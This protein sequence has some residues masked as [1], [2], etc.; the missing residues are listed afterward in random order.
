MGIIKK[1]AISSGSEFDFLDEVDSV[2]RSC[3]AS[4]SQ[5]VKDIPDLYAETNDGYSGS[6]SMTYSVGGGV[7]TVRIQTGKQRGRSPTKITGGAH[8][9]TYPIASNNAANALT[10]IV[11][12]QSGA[13]LT[14]VVKY[15]TQTKYA[16]DNAVRECRIGC[17]YNPGVL[18][19]Y[20]SDYDAAMVGT[21]S[22]LGILLIS[23]SSDHVFV[24]TKPGSS[25]NTTG[26]L[27]DNGAS[28][29]PVTRLP[30]YRDGTDESKISMIGSKVFTDVTSACVMTTDA[31]IDCST[32]SVLNRRIV[33]N[34]QTHYVL[35]AHTLVPVS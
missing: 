21:A 29:S 3:S 18:Y 13:T 35:N 6:P 24:A 8:A 20:F 32:L 22:S 23:G 15:C 31:L 17:V 25:N 2:F 27:L 33:I 16:T 4:I 1:S 19:L 28:V 26:Y 10:V 9:N 5:P 7:Y 34:G 30:Y 11:T 12:H 14:A